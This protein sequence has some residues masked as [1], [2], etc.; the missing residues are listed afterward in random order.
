MKKMRSREYIRKKEQEWRE[1]EREQYQTS[2]GTNNLVMMMDK[3]AE[4][5]KFIV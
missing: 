5:E 2:L 1:S 3:A 4:T